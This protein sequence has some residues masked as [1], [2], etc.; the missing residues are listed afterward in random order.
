MSINLGFAYLPSIHDSLMANA[1]RIDYLEVIPDGLMD[2]PHN[3]LIDR[4]NEIKAEFPLVAHSLDLSVSSPEVDELYLEGIKQVLKYFSIHHYSDH[5]AFTSINSY[6]VDAYLPPLFTEEH[7]EL[8]TTN[9]AKVKENLEK[10]NVD[11]SLENVPN[12]ILCNSEFDYS[13]G[14]FYSEVTRQTKVPLILNLDSLFMSARAKG[15]STMALLEEYPCD[16]IED[17][18]IVPAEAM[19]VVM[20][21]Q[22]G[23]AVN[24]KAKELLDEAL[25]IIS[26]K[27]VMIQVRYPEN[28]FEQLGTFVDTVLE[29][30]K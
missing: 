21:E 24:E 9:I 20:R 29:T 3:P 17:I 8:L 13:E 16:S 22:Y 26:P 1:S 15:V 28:T 27:R 18:T 7:L 25:T 11:F 30:I 23:E 12:L 10:D 6:N 4:I 14:A 2:T 5:L 19:N